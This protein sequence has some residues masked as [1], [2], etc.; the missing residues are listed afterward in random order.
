MWF[1]FPRKI[2]YILFS[3]TKQIT[4]YE[5]NIS[6]GNPRYV[7]AFI[8]KAHFVA[9]FF[10]FKEVRVLESVQMKDVNAL[11]GQHVSEMETFFRHTNTLLYQD[12]VR[13]GYSDI[14]SYLKGLIRRIDHHKYP[15]NFQG[16]RN[17]AIDLL[18]DSYGS[19]C[20]PA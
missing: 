18:A 10:V 7:V 5:L 1:D 19:S 3:N 14:P 4:Y 15:Q 8:Q 9:G 12:E 11:F 6:T 20:T 2:L 13:K 17:V 16:L